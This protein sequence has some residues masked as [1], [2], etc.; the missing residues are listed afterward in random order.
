MK[1]WKYMNYWHESKNYYILVNH[2]T[3]VNRPFKSMLITETAVTHELINKIH[4]M[5]FCFL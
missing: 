3:L 2:I 5:F 1:L 4:Q